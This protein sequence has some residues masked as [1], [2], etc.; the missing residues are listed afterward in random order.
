MSIF[1]YLPQPTGVKIIRVIMDNSMGATYNPGGWS[2]R[3][4][5]RI[6][7]HFKFNDKEDALLFVMKYGGNCSEEMPYYE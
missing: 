7:P 3:L 2:D 4:L 1:V 5:K 6:Q